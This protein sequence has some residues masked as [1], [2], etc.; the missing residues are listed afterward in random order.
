MRSQN[1]EIDLEDLGK[2]Y[3]EHSNEK[4]AFY[5]AYIGNKRVQFS[6]KPSWR[7]NMGNPLVEQGLTCIYADYLFADDN[8]ALRRDF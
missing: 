1:G 2:Q 7:E 4:K 5:R 3:R 8:S 6:Q